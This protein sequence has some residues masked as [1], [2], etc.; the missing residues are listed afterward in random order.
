[1]NQIK[2]DDALMMLKAV[3]AA[4]ASYTCLRPPRPSYAIIANQ[5]GICITGECTSPDGSPTCKEE[6]ECDIEYVSGGIDLPAHPHCIRTVH[7]E[8]RALL[9]AARY[10][11][12]TSGATIYSVNKPCYNCSK[13]IIVAG[14]AR[15]CY[16]FTVYD[17]PRTTAILQAA[18]IEVMQIGDVKEYERYFG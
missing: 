4:K 12:S 16:A 18:K 1:M 3:Q 13:A 9:N 7:A 8:V 10:G 17:E 5:W 15:I 2:L 14:I 6:G 11:V